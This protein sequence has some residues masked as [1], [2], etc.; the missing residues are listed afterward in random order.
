VPTT[1]EVILKRLYDQDI[2]VDS[3]ATIEPLT[4]GVSSDIF[5]VDDGRRR[6][7]V[8]QALDTL[9]VKDEWRADVN[10][11]ISEQE[12]IKHVGTFLPQV[13][14]ALLYCDEEDFFFVMEHLDDSFVNWKQQL[15]AGKASP[16]AAGEAGKT[17]GVIHR[18]TWES[19][20]V[21]EMFDTTENFHDL[22]TDPYL[23]TTGRRWPEIQSYCEEE[24]DRLENERLCLVHGDYS[25]KNILIGKERQVILDCEVAWYGDPAFDLAF[26]FNHF[27]LK[28]LYH[29]P[30]SAPFL[31]LIDSAWQA[32]LEHVSGVDIRDLEQRTARLLLI[33]LLARIDGMSPAEYIT[34]HSRKQAV[35][36]FV[37]R[38]LPLGGHS[39][40]SLRDRWLDH[41]V[42]SLPRS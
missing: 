21:R 19:D 8:K 13:V 2:I 37:C 42:K 35:R 6:V 5:L 16:S 33:L 26:L 31:A 39:F 30:D 11:N 29:F 3:K 22:R 7:V 20:A 38:E 9:K 12:Y 40:A 14:P 36:Q 10:R 4:G 24:A 41:L 27:M 32:Y 34:D 18:H 17:L 1:K 15:L 28:A 25:P 23:L